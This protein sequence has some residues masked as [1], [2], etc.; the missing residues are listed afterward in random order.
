MPV[1]ADWAATTM[2]VVFVV[3][4]VAKA[5]SAQALDDFAASL[6]QFAIR[7]IGAQRLAAAVVLLFEAAA[8]AGLLLLAAHPV[9]RFALPILLLIGFAGAIAASARRGRLTACHCFGTST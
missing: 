2:I 8:V 5:R 1:I 3:A 6:S 7:G 4:F 9:A